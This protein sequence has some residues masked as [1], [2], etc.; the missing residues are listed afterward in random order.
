VPPDHLLPERLGAVL[1]VL[2]L[3]FN[4]GYTASAGEALI[5]RELCA[6]AIRLGRA[7]PELMPD[8]PEVGGLLALMLLHDS[9]RAARVSEAGEPVLLAEQDRSHWDRAEIAEGQRLVERSLRLARPGSYQL[10]AAIAALHAE[11][12]TA[13]ATDWP[14]IAALYALLAKVNPSPIVELNRAASVAMA[15][16]PERGLALIDL[17]EVAGALDTYRWLHAAR[18]DL[19]RRLARFAEAGEAYRRALALAE[20]GAERAHLTR[21]LR[22]VKALT[23]DPL[24]LPWERGSKQAQQAA[25]HENSPSPTVGRGGRG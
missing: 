7:L 6:E 17:P 25:P 2:Y 14:Q 23:P 13:D 15:E 24:S 22:E 3:I 10:Q 11:A 20:N 9:R 21:R 12:A 8:E 1:A 18:A 16:G 4:E 5:R 19:L